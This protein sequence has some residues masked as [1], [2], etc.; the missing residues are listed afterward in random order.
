MTLVRMAD[1]VNP[2]DRPE[3][4]VPSPTYPITSVDNAFRLLRM[5]REHQ[6]LRLSDAS[7]RLGC[8]RSTAHRLLA[9][10]TYYGFAEQDPTTRA[11]R[12]GAAFDTMG[13]APQIGLVTEIAH[14]VL[15]L[16]A[17]AT[18]ETAHLCQVRGGS[19]QFLDTVEGENSDR[20]GSRR[21]VSYPAHCTSGGKVLLAHMDASVVRET[22]GGPELERLTPA[23][24]GNIDDLFVQLAGI[25]KRGYAMNLGESQS[26]VVAVAVAVQPSAPVPPVAITAAG[27]RRRLTREMLLSLAANLQDAAG[28]LGERLDDAFAT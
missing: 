10:L 18:G 27:P 15:R 14:P 3:A 11:Y 19:V 13:S 28:L 21:G 17:R 26:A 5:L 1:G 20:T 22:L 7:A 12:A 8:G 4:A 23:T 16:V 25:R 24:I 6:T 2:A 9:M